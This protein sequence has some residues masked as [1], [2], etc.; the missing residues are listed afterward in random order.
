M[1]D[2]VVSVDEGLLDRLS[3]VIVNIT[4]IQCECTVIGASVPRNVICNTDDE[5]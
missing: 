2:D 1:F 4:A 3:V 5:E